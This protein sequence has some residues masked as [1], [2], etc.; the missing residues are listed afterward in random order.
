MTVK[1][2]IE[3]KSFCL[4]RNKQRNSA[5]NGKVTCAMGEKT[6]GNH[7]SDEG[8]HSIPMKNTNNLIKNWAGA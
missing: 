5:R 8:F 4:A 7:V 6:F 3:L 1:Q 2:D